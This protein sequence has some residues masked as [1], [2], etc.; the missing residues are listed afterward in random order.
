MDVGKKKILGVA[1]LAGLALM[2]FFAGDTPTPE[3]DPSQTLSKSAPAE[4]IPGLPYRAQVQDDHRPANNAYP[5]YDNRTTGSSLDAEYPDPTYGY[6]FR[7]DDSGAAVGQPQRY[8]PYGLA[9][10]NGAEISN[11]DPYYG[12]GRP[13]PYGM[14]TTP[15]TPQYRFRPFDEGQSRRHHS[16]GFR[17]MSVLPQTLAEE[18][19]YLYR[20]PRST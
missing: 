5:H 6:R 16:G 10:P 3:S 4:R 17:P 12:S 2:W 15:A 8:Q 9:A 18:V 11:Q 20:L 14:D 13:G 19:R 1:V 7:P